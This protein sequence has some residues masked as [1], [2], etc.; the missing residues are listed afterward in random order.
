MKKSPLASQHKAPCAPEPEKNRG[1]VAWMAGNSVAAN[2]LMILFLVGG[3]ILGNNITQEVFPEI[4]L[5]TI[6]VSVV[7]QGASPEEIERSIIQAIEE[8]IQGIENVK[9]VTSTASE[10]NANVVVELVDGADVDRVW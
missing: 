7:Y 3:L 8:S 4:E 2:L 10:N 5:D 1:A 9:D 6:S